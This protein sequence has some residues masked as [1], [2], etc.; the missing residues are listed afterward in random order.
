MMETGKR[1]IVEMEEDVKTMEERLKIL[2]KRLK[3]AKREEA[4]KKI[5]EENKICLD[6]H[7]NVLKDEICFICQSSFMDGI[8][9]PGYSIMNY[10]C[11][12]SKV[13]TTHVT[14][15]SRFNKAS[16]RGGPKCPQ[17]SHIATFPGEDNNSV[18]IV[19]YGFTSRQVLDVDYS[20]DSSYD[21]DSL[22]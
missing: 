16:G 20:S 2:T 4:D 3:T 17:C 5:H 21:L 15:W 14:C 19:V 10:D 8:G 11:N 6:A 1:T 13:M 12:C 9:R 18:D 7:I 22:Q